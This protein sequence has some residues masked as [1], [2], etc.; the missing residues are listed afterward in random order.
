MLIL[1]VNTT[2]MDIVEYLDRHV[3]G[4][5]RNG[6]WCEMSEMLGPIGIVIFVWFAYEYLLI[7]M[8]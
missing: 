2:E 7:Y 8:R 6:R 3:C 1:S 5:E 4:Q